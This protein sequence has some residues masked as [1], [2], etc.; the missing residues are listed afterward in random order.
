MSSVLAVA[1]VVGALL[2]FVA[3]VETAAASSAPDVRGVALAAVAGEVGSPGPSTAGAGKGATAEKPESKLWWDAGS[4]W[5]VMWDSPTASWRIARHDRA[6]TPATWIFTSVVVDRRSDSRA[7]V[8][9]DAGKLYITSHVR[10][11]SSNAN[12]TG[13]PALL[14]RYTWDPSPRTYVLDQGFPVAVNDVSSETLV[15]DR[16]TS[17]RLWVTWTQGTKVYVNATVTTGDDLAWG[18]PFVLPADGSSGLDADDI[19]TVVAYRGRIG[20][21][22]SNQ[23]TSEVRFAAHEATNP[24]DQWGASVVVTLSG[25]GQ[26]DDHLNIKSLQSDD[27][28]R[29][30]AVIKTSLDDQGPS[31]PQIVVLARPRPVSGP[32]RRSG[33]SPTATPARSS[34]STRPTTSCTSTPRRP[35]AGA[36]TRAAPGTSSPRR[37]RCAPCPS[38]PAA[39]P[40]S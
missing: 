30:Y 21:L 34:S 35:T 27:S 5:A 1:A 2:V 18:T 10:A 33:P 31:A 36:P 13:Q 17:G 19:S 24:V 39:V 40:R 6:T 3:G 8:L 32:V 20:V 15:M 9:W 22:W 37:P 16:D 26:A 7:D 12:V 38:P 25:S 11:A 29:L 28:G 23:T 14:S 4:W